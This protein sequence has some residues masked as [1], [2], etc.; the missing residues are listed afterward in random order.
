LLRRGAVGGRDGFGS[1]SFHGDRGYDFD[2][3]GEFERSCSDRWFCGDLEP[4]EFGCFCSGVCDG[5]RWCDDGEL[6]DYDG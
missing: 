6:Y 3:D 4:D 5:C 2:W 1:E